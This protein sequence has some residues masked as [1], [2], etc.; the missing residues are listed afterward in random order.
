MYD[1][2]DT[3]I[4]KKGVF[5]DYGSCVYITLPV[6]FSN[7]K[8]FRKYVVIAERHFKA[9]EFIHRK[10]TNSWTG[11]TDL[12]LPRGG[13]GRGMDW[14]FGVRCKLLHLEWISI[15]ILLFRSTGNYI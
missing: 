7:I 11:R 14:E 4:V 9:G 13:R 6:P 1:Y 10:E 8:H 15:E 3:I 5:G 2:T 12:C